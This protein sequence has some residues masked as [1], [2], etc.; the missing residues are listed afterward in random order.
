MAY[1]GLRDWLKAL[2]AAGELKRV[3]AEVSPVLEIA[4]IADRA[5]KSGKGTKDAGGPA[6]LF[7]NVAGYKGARVLMNQFGSERRMRMA[8]EVETLDEI[9]KRIEVLLHPQAPVGL[10]DKLK[11]LPMLA[12]VGSFFPKVV[13]KKDAPCK[14][15]VLLGDDVDVLKFPVL[16]TWPA[17]GG[18]FITLPCVHTKDPKT[19]KRNVGMY[20]MQVYDGKTTGMHWQRQKVAAEHMRDRLRAATDDAVGAIDLMARTAGGSVA[21]V[22]ASSMPQHVVTKIRG[23]RMEV[24]VAIGTDPAVTFSAVVP[25]PPEDA[26]PRIAML[27]VPELSTFIPGVKRAT[28]VMSL[29]PLESI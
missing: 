15:V 3:K 20:R 12:E 10:M 29:T 8:L 7:E 27:A 4:E 6:L 2:E 25:A 24:A 26:M 21:A 9:A 1:D 19:G 14:E 18:P 11:M 13:G 28:S 23:E 22:D 16:T 17:D 5:A